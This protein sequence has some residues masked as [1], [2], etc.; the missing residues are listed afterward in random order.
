MIKTRP[1]PL[2]V[3]SIAEG[4]A[5]L[6]RRG[7]GDAVESFRF[8]AALLPAGVGEGSWIDLTVRVIAAPAGEDAAELRRRLVRDDGGD[9]KL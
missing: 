3:D 5:V 9:L 7:A 6:L 1:Q 2:F 8:P 4:V